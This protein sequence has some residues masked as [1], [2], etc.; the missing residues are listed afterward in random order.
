MAIRNSG[1]LPK[2]RMNLYGSKLRQLR[3][4]RRLTIKVVAERLQLAGWDVGE[5]SITHIE[6]GRRSIIDCELA[7]ILKA[8]GARLSDLER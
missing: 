3:K 5:T 7:L 4:E 2:G 6:L 1:G 8:I